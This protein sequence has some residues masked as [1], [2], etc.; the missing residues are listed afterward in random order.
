MNAKASYWREQLGK[1]NLELARRYHMIRDIT[2]GLSAKVRVQAELSAF[3]QVCRQRLADHPLSLT[4]DLFSGLVDVDPFWLRQTFEKDY[5]LPRE[6]AWALGEAWPALDLL[7]APEPTWQV[8]RAQWPEL[9]DWDGPLRAADIALAKA[10]GGID[11]ATGVPR[12]LILGRAGYKDLVGGEFALC[13]HERWRAVGT[14]RR[15]TMEPEEG[16][17]VDIAVAEKRLLLSTLRATRVRDPQRAVVQEMDEQS[18]HFE[19]L[20]RENRATGRGDAEGTLPE[21][22]AAEV[23]AELRAEV[24]RAMPR[25]GRYRYTSPAKNRW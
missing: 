4:V 3:W 18:A 19:G 23:A 8:L 17:S 12:C 22:L 14:R 21:A 20:L 11:P 24:Q 7:L 2:G 6:L 1:T 5:G 13:L 25:G 15:C 16:V 10:A 9:V